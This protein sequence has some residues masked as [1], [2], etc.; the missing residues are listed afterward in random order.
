MRSFIFYNIKYEYNITFIN[1]LIFHS[2]SYSSSTKYTPFTQL[3]SVFNNLNVYA[4]H[5]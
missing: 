3:S 1:G 2:H 5:K 4:V